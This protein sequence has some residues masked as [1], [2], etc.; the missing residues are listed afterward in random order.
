VATV[1]PRADFVVGLGPDSPTR[2]DLTRVIEQTAT[3]SFKT[4]AGIR[5]IDAAGSPWLTGY[6]GVSYVW[7]PD[8]QVTEL[9]AVEVGALPDCH[10]PGV[11]CGPDYIPAYGSDVACLHWPPPAAFPEICDRHLR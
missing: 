3:A 4:Q 11:T 1:V 10:A 9:G 8:G 7:T 2:L 5:A 6:I